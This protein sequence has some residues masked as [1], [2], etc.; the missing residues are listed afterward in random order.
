[1]V[2]KMIKATLVHLGTNMWYEVGNDRPDAKKTW[3]IGASNKLRFD[4]NLWVEYS[5]KLKQC[6][7]NTIVLDV[8]DG[9]VYDTH[10]ELKIEGSLTKEEMKAE[11]DRL[12]GMG[13][14][15]IPKLNFSTCH[16]VWLKEYSK[17]VSTKWY[18][19]VCADLIDEVCELFKPKYLHL[20]M[21]EEVYENQ[22]QYDYIV[23]PVYILLSQRRK[24]RTQV[25]IPPH[26]WVLTTLLWKQL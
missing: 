18:Y 16:D 21:D 19:Q 1:M 6:G 20:G 3:E 7:V 4:Y 23:P 13:F 14:E 26:L 24:T 25:N 9:I 17:M 5:E 8:G 2:E 11:L 12:Y 22:K 10:P 15:V